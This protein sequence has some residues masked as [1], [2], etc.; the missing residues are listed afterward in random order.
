[1]APH[2]PQRSSRPGQA[3]AR[4]DYPAQVMGP[5][6]GPPHPPAPVAPR[7]SRGAPRYPARLADL[8]ARRDGLVDV[9]QHDLTALVV[10]AHHEHFGDEGADLLG[11][12]VDDGDHPAADEVGGGVARGDLGARALDA[13]LG[14]EVDP[15]TVG[16]LARLR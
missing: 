1:M 7:P 14:A 2:T 4:L 16:G 13:Q 6:N 12:E 10:G 9:E 8:A 15:E 11:R 3:A 5:R